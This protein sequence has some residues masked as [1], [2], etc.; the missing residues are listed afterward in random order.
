MRVVP[1]SE[2]SAK[3]DGEFETAGATSD[4]SNSVRCDTG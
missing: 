1:L 3:A 4:N 2:F